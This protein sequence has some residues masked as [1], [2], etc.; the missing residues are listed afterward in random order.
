[1]N[2]DQFMDAVDRELE[3]KCGLCSADLE[4]AAYR[5]YF[6]D[7]MQPSEVADMVFENQEY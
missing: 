5:D 2:F 3:R 4:D 7:G 1:M 6:E